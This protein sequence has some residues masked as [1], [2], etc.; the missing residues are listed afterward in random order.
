MMYNSE[1]R[2]LTTGEAAEM[3]HL[4]PNTV[5]RWGDRGL[6]KPCRIG[7]RGDRRFVEVDVTNLVNSQSYGYK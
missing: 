7:P 5:R 4:H 2:L 3:L 6:L 1:N